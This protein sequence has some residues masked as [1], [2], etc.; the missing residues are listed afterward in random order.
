VTDLVRIKDDLKPAAF[1][2]ASTAL[3][4]TVGGLM[5]AALHSV[6]AG[7]SLLSFSWMIG[8]DLATVAAIGLGQGIAATAAALA[9]GKGEFYISPRRGFLA[10]VG[11]S[12]FNSLMY[13]IQ[14]AVPAT[15]LGWTL[16]LALLGAVG[17][18]AGWLAVRVPAREPEREL[19]RH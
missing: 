15:E 9:R 3:L 14:M 10:A 5:P 12:A 1:T 18:A 2:G 4:G 8:A 7:G 16:D 19:L 17:A 13:F 11:V 6:L